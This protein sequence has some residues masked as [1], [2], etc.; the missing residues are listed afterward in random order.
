PVSSAAIS[1]ASFWGHKEQTDLR[2]RRYGEAQH[3]GVTCLIRPLHPLHR[4]C[5]QLS[6]ITLGKES[7]RGGDDLLYLCQSRLID[8]RYGRMRAIL[9]FGVDFDRRVDVGSDVV[10]IQSDLD[11]PKGVGRV[12]VHFADIGEYER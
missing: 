9:D 5:L 1:T 12:G 11:S 6:Q 7:M 8:L 2:V 4:K 3:S 10:K